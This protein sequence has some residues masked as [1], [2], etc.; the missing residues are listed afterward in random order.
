MRVVLVVV[1]CVC[2]L[3]FVV[4]L[5]VICIVDVSRCCLFGSIV[6]VVYC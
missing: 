6:V 2:C 4:C 5:F 3:L 1:G